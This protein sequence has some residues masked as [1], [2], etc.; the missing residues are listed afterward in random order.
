M[1]ND[2]TILSLAADALMQIAFLITEPVDGD[3]PQESSHF[4]R[5]HFKGPDQQGELHLLASS[6]FA[7]EVAANLLAVE[8]HEVQAEEAGQALGELANI[9]GGEVVAALGGVEQ[10]FE[11]GL[12]EI[13]SSPPPPSSGA[14]MVRLESEEGQLEIRLCTR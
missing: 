8:P 13:L 12:P 14:T 11:L 10:P 7:N 3:S 4:A 1:L 5:I 9:L 6:G 2:E